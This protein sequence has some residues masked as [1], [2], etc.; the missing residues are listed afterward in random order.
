MPTY[1]CSIILGTLVSGGIVMKEFYMYES[2]QLMFIFIGSCIAICG[3]MYRVCLLEEED[4]FQSSEKH[5]EYDNNTVDIE[6]PTA[7]K[8][9]GS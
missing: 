1:E 5:S 9:T 6:G 2:K 7:L 8:K 3:I 4:L